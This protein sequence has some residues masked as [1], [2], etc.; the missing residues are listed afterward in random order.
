[1]YFSAACLI[2]MRPLFAKFPSL[3]KTRT[4]HADGNSGWRSTFGQR[5]EDRL[6]LKSLSHGYNSHYATMQDTEDLENGP[7]HQ[8]EADEVVLP[9]PSYQAGNRFDVVGSDRSE[10]RVETN[11][12]VRRD[13]GDWLYKGT[14][15]GNTDEYAYNVPAKSN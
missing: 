13:Q 1:M 8:S 3:L 7:R 10:I 5:T 12:E 6:R 9:L 15:G 2:G 14:A 4:S 11:I